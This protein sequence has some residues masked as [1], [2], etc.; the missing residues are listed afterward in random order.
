MNYTDIILSLLQKRN[1]IVCLQDLLFNEFKDF[2]NPKKAFENWCKEN[3]II[4]TFHPNKRIQL[5][6]KENINSFA[7]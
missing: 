6:A 2:E 1:S 3:S 5:S 7:E 4:Y